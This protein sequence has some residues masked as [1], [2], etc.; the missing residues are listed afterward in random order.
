MSPRCRTTAAAFVLV[1]L[2]AMASCAA[3]GYTVHTEAR[4]PKVTV[5]AGKNHP[6]SQAAAIQTLHEKYYPNCTEIGIVEVV[7]I[8]P[9]SLKGKVASESDQ[10]V[11]KWKI[12]ACGVTKIHP[13]TFGF[14]K[15]PS[16][17]GLLVG[18]KEAE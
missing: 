15:P 3:P 18:A 8:Q 13:V 5:P 11:E 16:G 14:S 7:D 12:L 6:P 2:S 1:C 4:A 9:P 17:P 10:W